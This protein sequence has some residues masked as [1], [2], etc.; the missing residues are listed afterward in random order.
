MLEKKTL[1]AALMATTFLTA[2]V[3]LAADQAMKPAAQPTAA[4]EKDAGKLSV[5]GTRAYNDLALTRLAIFDGRVKDAKTF[6]DEADTA[7]QKAKTD[8]SVF[9]KAEADLKSPAGAD[10][11]NDKGTSNSDPNAEKQEKSAKMYE[12]TTP[13]RWLPVDADMSVDEDFTTNTAKAAAVADANKSLAKGDKQGALDQAETGRGGYECT[14]SSRRAAR[15]DHLR[16]A[17]GRPD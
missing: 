5:D 8:D 6:V 1:I 14:C 2:G 12:T 15:P 3:A 4:I 16:R 10:T 17:P 7:F 11:A 13:K 9:M